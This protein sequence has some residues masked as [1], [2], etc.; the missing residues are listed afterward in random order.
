MGPSANLTR[1]A[2][3]ALSLPLAA[4]GGGSGAM[5]GGVVSTPPPTYSKLANLSGNQT[6]QAATIH[7]FGPGQSSNF[8]SQKYGSGVTISYTASSDSYTLTAPDGTT[9]IVSSSG[10]SPPVHVTPPPGTKIFYGPAGAFSIATPSVNGV[11]LS[12][13]AIADW[14]H[15]QNAIQS[16][17]FGVYGV[18]TVASDMPK[19]GTATY[20]TSIN[21]GVF[22]G[23]VSP[24]S[25]QS[26]STA[27]FSANFANGT[28]ATTLNLVGTASFSPSNLNLGSFSGTGTIDA[29]GPGFSGTLASAASNPYTGSGA[30]SGAFFGPQ[31]TEMGYAWYLSGGNFTAQGTVVGK[32]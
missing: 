3:F 30:F 31:A 1:V 10:S 2:L 21:G 13:V 25:L 17:Y 16:E 6:F 8:S 24:Y 19:S 12:Y 9:D 29:G 28:V 7:Y 20:Q 22:P 18:P 15:M 32:K 4:C 5:G 26:Q 11:A 23:N 27:T 14:E